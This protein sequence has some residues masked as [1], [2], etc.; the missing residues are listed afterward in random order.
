[1]QNLAGGR[2]VEEN[3]KSPETKAMQSQLSSVSFVKNEQELFE[4]VLM[5]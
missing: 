4:T 3:T 5:Q 2:D 1:M